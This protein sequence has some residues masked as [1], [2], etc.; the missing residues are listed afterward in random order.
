MS[1]CTYKSKC[2]TILDHRAHTHKHRL[3]EPPKLVPGG[4]PQHRETLVVGTTT[5][6]FKDCRGVRAHAPP[7]PSPGSGEGTRDS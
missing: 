7:K 6:L 3:L 5:I 2:P 1:T 4:R